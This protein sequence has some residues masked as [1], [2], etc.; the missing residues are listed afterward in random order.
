MK[1]YQRGEIMD[2][3]EYKE[4]E[5]FMNRNR[6]R[7][8][9]RGLDTGEKVKRG[10]LKQEAADIYQMEHDE[11]NVKKNN[12]SLEYDL[13]P[14]REC[15]ARSKN[16]SHAHPP[17]EITNLTRISANHLLLNFTPSS[18]TYGTQ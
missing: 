8:K 17:V 12:K 6:N 2:D 5:S 15:G 10:F 16:P 14:A 18:N 3:R 7:I 1:N 13:Q 11:S 9:L 4:C